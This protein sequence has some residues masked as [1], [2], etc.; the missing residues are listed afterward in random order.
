MRTKKFLAL[1]L[2]LALMLSA[3]SVFAYDDGVVFDHDT[4]WADGETLFAATVAGTTT[5]TVAG[6]ANVEDTIT[7]TGD[8]TINGGTLKRTSA[9]GTLLRVNEG[10]K[11]ELNDVTIDG[12]NIEISAGAAIYIVGGTAVMNGG[13]I[14]NHK[15]TGGSDGSAVCISG[16]KFTLNGGTIKNCETKNYGGAV[17]MGNGA[18]FDFKSGLFENCKTVS[19]E[20]GYGGGAFYVRD[21]TLKM[22]GGTIKDCSSNVGGAIYNSSYGTTVITGGEIKN[23]TSPLGG[24]IFHSCKQG[25]NALLQ[26]GGDADIDVGNDIY[27]MNGSR[28]DK[29]IEIVS[30]ISHPLMLTVDNADEGRV[31]ATAAEGVTLTDNDMAKLRI[32][33][34][35]YSLALS[36][37][38][39]SLTEK[40]EESKETLFL[41]FSANG[42]EGEPAGM[43]KEVTSGESA[44]FIIPDTEP[45]RD[46]FTFLGWSTDKDA[47]TST[48]KKGD[49]VTV[50]HNTLLYAIWLADDAPQEENEFTRA[51]SITG[52]T[53]GDEPNAP[54]AAAKFGEVTFKY[55]SERDGEYSAE[56]PVNAGTYFVCAYVAETEAYKGLTSEPEEFTIA[57]KTINN[58]VKLKAPYKNAVAETE[59]ETEEYNATVTWNPQVNGRFGYNTAYEATVTIVPKANYTVSG[60][61][62][63]GYKFDSAISVS[64]AENSGTVT[65]SYRATGKKSSSGGGGGTGS[66]TLLTVSFE[67]NGGSKVESEKVFKNSALKEPAAPEKEGFTFA[68]WYSDKE[69]KEK[70]DFSEKVTGAMTLYAAWEKNDAPAKEIILTVGEKEAEVFG[71]TKENDVAPK[72]VNERTMLPARFVAENLGATVSWNE[73]DRTVTIKGKDEKGEEVVIII[74]VGSDKATVNG[75]EVKLDSPAFIENGR[76]YTPLRFISEQ[77]GATVKWVEKEEKV[78]IKRSF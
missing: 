25:D 73:E 69:L 19:N 59:L 45:S 55:A 24:A 78:I 14:I 64:N 57:P 46:G 43:N 33:N 23:N 15:K 60:I 18:E 27:L 72:I 42:G 67:S 77:L 41:G 17:Y 39:I 75:K 26:I 8:V 53:Y 74:T 30:A 47:L 29:C 3:G 2:A 70:Y 36:D 13:E 71:K 56:V 37:N 1:L 5:V 7:I 4:T 63:N 31:I 51:L 12:D 20:T 58:A 52:W 66:A 22:S 11:L 40:T 35:D 6:T 65:V 9:A 54:D 21:A 34:A 68:G 49:K 61:A 48:Y 44:E 76:T 16:G 62:E 28:V 10:A 32:S 38:K 50:S